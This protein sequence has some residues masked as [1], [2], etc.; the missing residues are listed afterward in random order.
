MTEMYI[1]LSDMARKIVSAKK[2]SGSGNFRGRPWSLPGATGVAAG[3]SPEVR[4]FSY[5]SELKS[6]GLLGQVCGQPGSQ[7]QSDQ[8]KTP[9]RGD[10]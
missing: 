4:R 9:E 2:F 3:P 6:A 8:T 7:Y 10:E 1:Y 5:S